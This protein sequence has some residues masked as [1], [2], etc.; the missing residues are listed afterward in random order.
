VRLRRHDPPRRGALR[1]GAG[2]GHP[3][4][5]RP[6]HRAADMLI[7]GGTSLVVLPCGRPD[8]YYRGHRRCSSSGTPRPWTAAP[9]WCSR[10]PGQGV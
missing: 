10:E 2:R 8:Q 1:G 6:G 9:T 5:E 7:I 3:G 4:P